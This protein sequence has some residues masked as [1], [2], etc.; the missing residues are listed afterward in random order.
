MAEVLSMQGLVIF[1]FDVIL[2]RLYVRTKQQL[3]TVESYID[4]TP[5]NGFYIRISPFPGIGWTENNVTRHQ[6]ETKVKIYRCIGIQTK[7]LHITCM[8]L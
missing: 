6:C 3:S 4:K 5:Y 7:Q 8:Y 1:L 2:P